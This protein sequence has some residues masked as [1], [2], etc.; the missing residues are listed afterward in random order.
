MKRLLVILI[1]LLF[2]ASAQGVI[3][4]TQNTPLME[5]TLLTATEDAAGIKETAE[6]N[7]SGLYQAT[8]HI[9]VCLVEASAH[10]GTEVIVQIA[11]EAAV[12]DS[13]TDLVRFGM[14]ATAVAPTKADVNAVNSTTTVYCTDPGTAN[15]DECGKNI[16]IY[17]TDTIANSCIAYQVTPGVDA[18]GGHDLITVL[19]APLT[20]DT[21]CDIYTVTGD[22]LSAVAQQTCAI[23]PSISRVRVIIN[24]FYDNDGTAANVVVRVR[25]TGLSV[26]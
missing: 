4:K 2:C 8:L 18:G 12:N 14:A 10:E 17:D 9:D 26:L 6:W 21:D 24:N 20:T 5:W 23:P 15:L 11:S 7:T 16:F 3:T 25:G 22:N 13:W 1:S 19:D